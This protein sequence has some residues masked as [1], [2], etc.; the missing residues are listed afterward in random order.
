VTQTAAE[1]IDVSIGPEPAAGRPLAS[2]SPTYAPADGG[3]STDTVASVLIVDDD[4]DGVDALRY[5]LEGQGY[6]VESAGNGRDALTL[7][8]RRARPC[9]VILDLAMPVMNGWQF[10]AARASDASLSEIPVIVVTA[11]VPSVDAETQVVM[12]KPVDVD[13]LIARIGDVCRGRGSDREH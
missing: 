10:L 11:S 13:A 8:R 4:E 7:L 12:T 1:A 3:P 2:A 9:V 6:H 5:A